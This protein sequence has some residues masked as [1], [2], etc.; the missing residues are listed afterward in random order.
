VCGHLTTEI[1]MSAYVD[2]FELF[3]A[4]TTLYELSKFTTIVFSTDSSGSIVHEKGHNIFNFNSFPEL[5]MF[6]FECVANA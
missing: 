1:A 6:L 4:Y 5:S 2:F 3:Q